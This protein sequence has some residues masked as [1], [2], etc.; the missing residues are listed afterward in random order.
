MGICMCMKSGCRMSG[1]A[2]GV[3]FYSKVRI[4]F[5]QQ[6]LNESEE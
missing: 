3:S 5:R 6:N 4:G 2:K 1:E